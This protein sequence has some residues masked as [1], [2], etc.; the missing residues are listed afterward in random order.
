LGLC[1]RGLT[2]R[3]QGAKVFRF[4]GDDLIK[5]SINRIANRIPDK[6]WV[7]WFNPLL[8]AFAPSREK[9]FHAN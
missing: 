5:H 8:C 7:F 1:R 3:R 9:L 4:I 6:P 2:Q